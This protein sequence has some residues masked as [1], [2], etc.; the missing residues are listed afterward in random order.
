M[1]RYSVGFYHVMLPIS[2]N[3]AVTRCPSVC[4]SHAGIVSKRLNISSSYFTVEFTDELTTQLID[5]TVNA[6][7]IF[8]QLE[9][10]WTDLI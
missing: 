8:A 7:L 2:A 4:L 3:C 5:M 1:L 9:T 6:R 10:N